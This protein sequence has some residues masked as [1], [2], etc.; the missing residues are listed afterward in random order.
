M[1]L[2]LIPLL[3]GLTGCLGGPRDLGPDGQ[4]YYPERPER[5]GC[6]H[7]AGQWYPACVDEAEPNAEGLL[8]LAGCEAG[9][10]EPD[11]EYA[12]TRPQVHRLAGC[13]AVPRC[14]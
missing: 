10:C 14:E 7:D 9:I 4:P 3:L 2:R 11:P 5:P 8:L 1:R 13:E 6:A 12:D